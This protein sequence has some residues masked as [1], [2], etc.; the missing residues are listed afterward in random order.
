ML[1]SAIEARV[2]AL[3]NELHCS[4]SEALERY[5]LE[6][7]HHNRRKVEDWALSLREV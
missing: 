3:Q 7:Q 4:R 6:W 5:R 2:S 1:E